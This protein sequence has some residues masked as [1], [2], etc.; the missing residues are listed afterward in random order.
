MRIT[1]LSI[2]KW[3]P[4]PETQLFQEYVRRTPWKIALV[5]KKE[6]SD[7]SGDRKKTKEGRLLLAAAPR[8]GHKIALD[9]KGKHFTSREFAARL[10]RMRDEG[11]DTLSFF[12]GGSDGL[13]QELRETC[14]AVWS[15]SAMTIPHYLVRVMLSEQLYRACTILS[16]HPY[17]RE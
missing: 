15:L 4:G 16:G 10:G 5:E 14:D 11:A 17:H 12:I 1:I 13:S 3:K 8:D 6:L 7:L 9:E 2:G